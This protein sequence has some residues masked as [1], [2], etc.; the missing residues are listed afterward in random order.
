[1]NVIMEYVQKKLILLDMIKKIKIIKKY[2]VC[3]SSKLYI[4]V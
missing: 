4:K 3:M 2:E 1:L